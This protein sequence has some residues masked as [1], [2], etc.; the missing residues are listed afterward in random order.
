MAPLASTQFNT[1]KS[2]LK[3]YEAMSVGVPWVASPR[4]EYRRVH[5]ACPA[6]LLVE[7]RKDWYRAVKQLMDDANLRQDLGEKGREY[8]KSQTVEGNSW[9][10]WEAWERA[11][12]IQRG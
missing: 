4:A 8:M 6:G 3:I 1:S 7:G 11:L 12:K 5:A 10:L 2:A 9:R